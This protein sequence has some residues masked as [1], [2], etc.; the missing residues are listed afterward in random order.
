[1]EWTALVL[2]LMAV[3]LGLL[4]SWPLAMMEIGSPFGGGYSG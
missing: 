3:L 2:A 4:T 1:M